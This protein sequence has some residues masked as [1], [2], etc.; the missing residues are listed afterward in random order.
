MDFLNFLLDQAGRIRYG[1]PT[2]EKEA[3]ARSGSLP[4][5]PEDFSAG[6]E[7]A[8]RYASGFLFGQEHPYISQMVQP[9]VNRIKTSDLP[10]LG[11][12]S[13]ELQSYASEGARRGAFSGW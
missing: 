6:Q 4:G 3:L 7:K 5:A 10:F 11:G 13:P 2:S 8:D 9:L 12:S 1:V